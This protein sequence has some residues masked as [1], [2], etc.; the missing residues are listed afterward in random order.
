LLR[1]RINRWVLQWILKPWPTC[2]VCT[3]VVCCDLTTDTSILWVE[4]Y[5]RFLMI[6]LT[7]FWALG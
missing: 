5:P 1:F 7:F 4:K 6:W 3:N 2:G